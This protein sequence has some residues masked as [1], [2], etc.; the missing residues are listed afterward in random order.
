MSIRK[1]NQ[2]R[3]KQQITDTANRTGISRPTVLLRLYAG[4]GRASLGA[5]T[6]V[7]AQVVREWLARGAPA[8]DEAMFNARERN[9]LS[10]K[11]G[12]ARHEAAVRRQ[13]LV[14]DARKAEAAKWKR[15]IA[16]LKATGAPGTGRPGKPRKRVLKPPSR[17]FT[18]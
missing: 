15:R 18:N 1:E 14:A 2:E 7:Q 10:A 13:K 5:L 16:K 11:A 3:L 6:T 8:M 17:L 12:K 9:D 4:I